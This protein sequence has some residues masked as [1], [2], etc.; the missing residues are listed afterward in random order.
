MPQLRS[1]LNSQI[2]RAKAEI[3]RLRAVAPKSGVGTVVEFD[4]ARF[5]KAQAS[6]SPRVKIGGEM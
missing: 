6:V 1:N 2:E 4:A 3:I 5:R